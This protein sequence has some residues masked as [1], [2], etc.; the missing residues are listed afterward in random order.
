[1][2]E[3]ELLDYGGGNLGSL[4]RC[5]ERLG[6]SFALVT[7]PSGDRPLILPG[8]GAFGAVMAGLSEVRLR[9]GE[10]LREGTPYLGICVGLQILLQSSQESPGVEGLGL[11]EGEV[12]RFQAPKVP[13]MGW[14]DVQARQSG[15]PEGFVYFV[16]SYYAQPVDPTAVLYQAEYHGLFCAAIRQKNLTAFQFHPEKSGAFGEQLLRHWKEQL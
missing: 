14:N 5:L 13:Q 7:Q 3:L 9:L 11:I 8:V 10:I 4:R 6:W 1:M 16:N 2:P 12:V 15:W